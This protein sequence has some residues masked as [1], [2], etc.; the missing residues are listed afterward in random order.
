M[1]GLRERVD[2]MTLNFSQGQKSLDA[3]VQFLGKIMKF[4]KLLAGPDQRR[5]F[6]PLFLPLVPLHPGDP[7]S[8]RL[9]PPP[10]YVPWLS[11]CS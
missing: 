11:F 5:C 9:V 1:S 7:F 8:P 6:L 4:V 10:E 2:T 3:S